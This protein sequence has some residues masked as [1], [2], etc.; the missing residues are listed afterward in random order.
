MKLFFPQKKKKIEESRSASTN[1]STADN[2]AAVVDD[3]VKFF[4]QFHV[5]G[6]W[7][8]LP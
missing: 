6:A 2:D 5:F 4:S 1:Q 8:S 3:V 7:S